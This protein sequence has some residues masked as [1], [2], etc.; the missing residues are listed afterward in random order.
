MSL[1]DETH[2]HHFLQNKEMNEMYLSVFLMS[3][4]QSIISIFVPIY[5]YFLGY[6][7]EQILFYFFLISFFVVLFMPYLAQLISK[8]GVKHS[9]SISIPF[10]IIYFLGL[11]ILD[12]S[13]WLFYILPAVIAV[14]LALYNTSYHLNYLEHED[15]KHREKQVSIL[16]AIPVL[17]SLLAPF[18]GGLVISAFGYSYLYAVG[19]ILLS[20][21]TIPLL[22]TK[23]QKEKMKFKKIDIFKDIINKKRRNISLSFIGY[24]SA[25]TIGMVV[26]PIFLTTLDISTKYIGMIISFSAILTLIIFY[27]IEEKKE[28][29]LKE[30]EIKKR[31]FLHTLGWIGRM[32]ADSMFLAFLVDFYKKI[33]FRLLSVPWTTY[34]YDIAKKQDYFRFIVSREV[35]FN[36]SRMLFLP[37]LILLFNINLMPFTLSFMLAAVLSLLYAKIV[38]V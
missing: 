20:V 13:P 4:A 1:H 34:T 33:A 30:K 9:I 32:F 3:L 23:D 24:A 38:K 12:S 10:Y 31:T 16:L 15:A 18:F 36:I 35:T 7:I 19:S 5:L 21:S 2:L 37:I 11:S 25:A 14:R 6:S 17:A 28:K 8:I 27:F 22:L 26:W 29:E